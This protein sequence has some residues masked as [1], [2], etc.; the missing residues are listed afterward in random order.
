[1]VTSNSS[2]V[3]TRV[4][5]RDLAAHCGVSVSTVS[6]AMNPG[7]NKLIRAETRDRILR[8]AKEVG[9]RP[10]WVARALVNQRTH[11]IALLYKGSAPALEG[12]LQVMVSTL[13]SKLQEQGYYLIFL[14]SELSMKADQSLFDR[15][16]GFVLLDED[17]QSETR[18][19]IQSTEMPLVILNGQLPGRAIQIETD[20]VFGARMLTNHL[21]DLGHQRIALYMDLDIE[22]DVLHYSTERRRIGYEQSMRDAGLED[23]IEV[24]HGVPERLAER[25]QA[26]GPTAPTAIAVHSHVL[27]INLM[28]ELLTRGVRLPDN[29]S[30]ATFNDVYPVAHMAPALTAISIPA[31]Q[32]GVAAAE[33]LLQWADDPESLDLNASKQFRPFLKQRASTISLNDTTPMAGVGGLRG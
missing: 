30:L 22:G 32:M 15:V 7:Y 3:Q 28:G 6:K 24:I 31:E 8:M 21:T 14:P 29:L 27:A 11:T 13:S 1:V 2:D 4:T 20:D 12:N 5:I 19:A 25:V 18:E 9:Y 16:D 17:C 10:S 33:Y 23:H 26:G